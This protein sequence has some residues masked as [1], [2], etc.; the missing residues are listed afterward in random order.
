MQ[1]FR[2]EIEATAASNSAMMRLEFS[3]VSANWLKLRTLKSSTAPALMR[4]RR[5]RVSLTW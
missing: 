3:A 1:E 2:R 4:W 5:I